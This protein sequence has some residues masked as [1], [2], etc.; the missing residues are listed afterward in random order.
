MYCKK[1]EGYTEDNADQRNQ[2]VLEVL[3][4]CD[5]S[6]VRPRAPF[7]TTPKPPQE[8]CHNDAEP[9]VIS[10][11]LGVVQGVSKRRLNINGGGD[12]NL[13]DNRKEVMR[14]VQ[15]IGC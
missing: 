15:V 10:C 4:N 7:G 6:T 3:V 8:G 2:T 1:S 11:L 14:N 9:S 13:L 5:K 12:F